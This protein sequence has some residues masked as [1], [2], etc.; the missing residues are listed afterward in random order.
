MNRP[1]KV[2]NKLKIGEH[3]EILTD[4][5]QSSKEYLDLKLCYTQGYFA[6]L[7]EFSELDNPYQFFTIE[8]IHWGYGYAV[9]FR[10]RMKCLT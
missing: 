1:I 7:E 2:T 8:W 4:V 5:W 9:A 6:E 3:D 10:E